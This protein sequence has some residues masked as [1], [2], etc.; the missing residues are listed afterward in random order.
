M[1]RV[2]SHPTPPHPAPPRPAAAHAQQAANK[3]NIDQRAP[4]PC[5][6]GR[7][8]SGV[9]PCA[10]AVCVLGF[11]QASD[12][13]KAM[14]GQDA[15]ETGMLLVVDDADVVMLMLDASQAEA[16][17]SARDLTLS[18]ERTQGIDRR[19]PAPLPYSSRCSCLQPYAAAGPSA[20]P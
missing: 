2:P 15:G 10:D 6:A 19:G 9:C 4:V 14:A 20:A 16:K 17:L 12:R 1:V 3:R 7:P 18:K 13:V 5:L 11:P 8:R